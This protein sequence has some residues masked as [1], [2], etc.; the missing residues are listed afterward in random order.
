MFYC[1][2]YLTYCSIMYCTYNIEYL[3]WILTL[4]TDLNLSFHNLH[5]CKYLFI[6]YTMSI[7]IILKLCTQCVIARDLVTK[8]TACT[9]ATEVMVDAPRIIFATSP[10]RLRVAQ[11]YA[12]VCAKQR[13]HMA[14]FDTHIN[15][16][17]ILL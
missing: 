1:Y 3:K 13:C 17:I 7:V 9:H 15:F 16:V 14:S 2:Y 10:M 6:Y 4:I 5:K 8:P 11:P 12:G